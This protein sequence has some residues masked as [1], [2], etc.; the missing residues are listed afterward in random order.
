MVN[1]FLHRDTDNLGHDIHCSSTTKRLQDVLA[2]CDADAKCTGVQLFGGDFG[3]ASWCTKN[4]H[5]DLTARNGL[6][7]FQK[8]V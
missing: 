6:Q 7:Y 5:A 3:N 1:Y 2:T 4:A 8:Q